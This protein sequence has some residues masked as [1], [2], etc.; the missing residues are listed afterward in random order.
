M[1][2]RAMISLAVVTIFSYNSSFSFASEDELKGII[3]SVKQNESLYNNIEYIVHIKYSTGKY[4]F[5]SPDVYTSRQESIHGVLQN[6]KFRVEVEEEMTLGNGTD[7]S[8]ED[9]QMFDGEKTRFLRDKSLG[10]IFTGKK[11]PENHLPPHNLML[12]RSTLV[13]PLSVLLTGSQAMQA[14]P[15]QKSDPDYFFEAKYIGEKEFNGLV[16]HLV[17]LTSGRLKP[18]KKATVKKVFWLVESK[19]YL[20]VRIQHYSLKVSNEIVSA[21]GSIDEFKEVE[22]G[23]WFPIKGSYTVYNKPLLK[24]ERKQVLQ[25]RDDFEVETVL[26]NPDYELSF[27]NDLEFPD[28]VAVYEIENDEI[29]NSYSQGALADPKV[30]AAPANRWWENPFVIVNVIFVLMIIIYMAWKRSQRIDSS[31]EQKF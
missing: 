22:P 16:C 31:A 20:P 1:I 19:N 23:L 30:A 7:S 3:E 26:F 15:L 2:C 10:N 14:D 11:I 13:A 9:I 5:K 8:Y 24:S 25:W 29:V 12:H 6:G 28:G 17:S 21:E 27:F 18:E 4:M